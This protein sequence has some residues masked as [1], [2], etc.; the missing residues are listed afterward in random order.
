MQGLLHVRGAAVTV[1]QSWTAPGM[2]GSG[3]E[4]PDPGV[5]MRVN[6][7]G[8]SFA[9]LAE[10]HRVEAAQPE[11]RPGLPSPMLGAPRGRAATALLS[12]V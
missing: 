5:I 6:P 8:D 4:L 3:L 12:G 7:D 10:P 11:D 9:L 1:V 2:D